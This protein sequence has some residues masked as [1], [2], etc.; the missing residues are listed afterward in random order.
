[1][2]MFRKTLMS[3]AMVLSAAPAFA[4]AET[5][6]LTPPPPAP[7]QELG[8]AA[9]VNDQVITGYD[10]DQRIRLLLVSTGTPINNDTAQQARTPALRQLVDENLQM[11]EA[12]K[13]SI[14]VGDDDVRKELQR[15][16][17][18]SGLQLEQFQHLL[19]QAGIKSPTLERQIRAELAWNQTVLRRFGGRLSVGQ[20][21]VQAAIDRIKAN[22]GRPESLVSEI[23]IAVDNPEQEEQARALVEQLFQQIKQGARFSALARQFSQAP[24]AANGGDIGWI[25]PGQLS[26]ELDG[27]LAGIQVNSVSPPVRAA[28]GWYILGLRERRQT[29]VTP[30]DVTVVELKQV[31]VPVAAG[32]DDGTIA[33]LRERMIAETA[34]I[35]G[36]AVPRNS[37]EALPGSNFG[38]IGR[39]NVADLPA[40]YAA[41]IANLQP[42][43]HSQPVRSTEGLHVLILCSRN[44]QTPDNT[45]YEAVQ[46]SLEDQQISML[47]RRYLRDLRRAATIEIR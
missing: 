30:P 42:G 7:Q 45:M 20:E 47:A 2:V 19:V 10:L 21:Q 31:F 11:T 18:A 32:A 24:S 14:K 28:G 3:L 13:E 5:A 22:A 1:M 29:P 41:A 17:Q 43:Q 23:M 12:V 6:A 27:V 40:E 26:A 36:C 8:I 39:M 9:V 46:R 15:I 37:L 33:A 34:D 38:E 16:I 44:Q 25:Q 35:E 4:Q